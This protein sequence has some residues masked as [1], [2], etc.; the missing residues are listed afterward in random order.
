MGE[1]IREENLRREK[2]VVSGLAE[3]SEAKP[4]RLYVG[5]DGTGAPMRGGG[6]R[7][8]KTG[9]IYQ[10]VE[11]DGKSVVVD[12]GYLATLE[13]TESFGE[14]VYT[15]AYDRGVENAE[16]IVALGDGAPWIW[17]SHSH[18]YPKAVQILDYYHACEHL[19]DVARAWYGEGTDRAKRWVDARQVDL[20]SDC[21]ETVIRSIQSWRPTDENASEVRRTN[22]AYF[23]TN[24]ERMRYATFKAEGYHIGSGLVESACKM[25]VGQRL[26]QSG[27]RWSQPG[28][29]AMLSLRCHLLTCRTADLRTYARAI[30]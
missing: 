11:R 5:I 3:A 12:P 9:V 21:A 25:V 27:M 23:V 18:H 22:L 2:L 15:A 4:K 6:T 30:T 28:A 24:K 13:R 16:D 14:Q 26:K 19:N 17:K 29:E 7:E 1:L 8:V 20:L 10:T